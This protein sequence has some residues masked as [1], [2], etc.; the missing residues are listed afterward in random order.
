M[1]KINGNDNFLGKIWGKIL[2][3]SAIASTNRNYYAFEI[4]DIVNLSPI[5]PKFVNFSEKSLANLIGCG[6]KFC[7]RQKIQQKIFLF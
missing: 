1:G 3:Q 5:N 7:G 6:G 4:K 2:N